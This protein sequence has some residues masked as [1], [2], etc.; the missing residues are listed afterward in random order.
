VVVFGSPAASPPLVAVHPA[1]RR[2]LDLVAHAATSDACVLVTG[3][4]GTG[5]DHF[6]REIHAR[7][8]RKDGP[9]IVLRCASLDEPTLEAELAAPD[10]ETSVF[11]RASGGTLVLDEVGSLSPALQVR[12]LSVLQRYAARPCGRAA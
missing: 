7:S 10:A 5:K 6:A 12:L 8:S 3:E 2:A 1:S 11:H 4:A 9:F